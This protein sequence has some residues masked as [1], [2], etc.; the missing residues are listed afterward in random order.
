MKHL[1]LYKITRDGRTDYDEYA[2]FVVAAY[3]P[4]EARSF[5]SKTGDCD[6]PEGNPQTFATPSLSTL[7]V[8]GRAAEGMPEGI[9][10]RD[11]RAG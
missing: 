7:F 3:S 1:T 9:V 8:I 4:D 6:W 5:A 11:F 2:G 10:L